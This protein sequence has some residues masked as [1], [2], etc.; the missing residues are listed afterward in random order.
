MQRHLSELASRTMVKEMPKYK[1]RQ[2][3]HVGIGIATAAFGLLLLLSAVMPTPPGNPFMM[4]SAAAQLEGNLTTH[5]NETLKAQGSD[6]QGRLPSQEGF[7]AK[8]LATNFSAPHNILYGPD[9]LL[10]ITERVGKN[11]TLVDPSNGSKLKSIPVPNVHQS[12]GQDGLLGMAFDPN[13]NSTHHIYVAYTYDADTSDQLDR[14]TKITRFTY[15]VAADTIGEPMDLISGLKGS[16]DHNSARMAFGQDGKIYY[17]IGDQGKNQLTLY[18]MNIEAQNLPTAGEVANKN[19]TMYQ[20]KVLRMNPDG[21]IPKDNPAIDGVQSHIYTYGHRNPQGLT[22]GPN[23]DPYVAEHGP[24]TDDEVNH[25]QSGGNYGW[26]YVA[27]YKD[28]NAYRYVNWSST[29]ENCPKLKYSNA[30]PPPA[31]VTVMNETD[32]NAPNFVPPVATFYTVKDDYNFTNP[33]CGEMAY[34]CNP[35]VAPSSLHTYTFGTIPGWNNT[36]LMTTLKA[37]KIFQLTLNENGTSLMKDPTALFQSENR[38]RDLAFSPDGSTLYVI[39]DS[40]GP[41]QA[42]GGG[43]TTDLWNPGSLLE[44]RYIGNN[45]TATQ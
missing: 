18:C 28:D 1:H 42:I 44:F 38:Y 9:D 33:K 43:A 5:S 22:M 34:I 3:L 4:Q 41:A 31:G 27:G 35:T 7:S 19:W 13:F 23:G 20:G 12:G 2:K 29:G 25:L 37:G 32:F 17:T 6:H 21:S 11:I 8:V 39:T 14:N 10:W 36:M 26:P 45:S 40:F 16:I 24:N 15:N 30:A